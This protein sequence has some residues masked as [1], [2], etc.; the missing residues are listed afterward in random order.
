MDKA[1]RA[2]QVVQNRGGWSSGR[3]DAIMNWPDWSQLKLMAWWRRGRVKARNM[4]KKQKA[5]RSQQTE[6]M[7]GP[8]GQR[9]L[10]ADLW[11]R[12]RRRVSVEG[13]R[14]EKTCRG[15]GDGADEPG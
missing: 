9:R 8:R 6:G 15:I 10:V 1:K 2:A 12:V 5:T 13:A 3:T 14:E 7:V 11:G 4:E